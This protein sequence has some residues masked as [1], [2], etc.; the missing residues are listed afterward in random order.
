MW[1]NVRVIRNVKKCLRRQPSIYGN[2]FTNVRFSIRDTMRCITRKKCIETFNLIPFNGECRRQCPV[3][4]SQYHPIT[5]TY[6]QY[7]CFKCYTK[8]SKVCSGRI[9]K[10]LT[11]LEDFRECNI[12]NGSLKIELGFNMISVHEQLEQTLGNIETINGGLKI[13]K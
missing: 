6:Y 12:V 7:E 13:S 1:T 2:S 4:F 10:G 5:K 9:I 3:S 8:C 11:D